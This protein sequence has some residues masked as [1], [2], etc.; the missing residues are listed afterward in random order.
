LLLTVLLVVALRDV[1]RETIVV[2]LLYVLWLVRL[3][4]GSMPQ[5]LFWSVFL[6]VACFLALGSLAREKSARH[7][8]G[9]A[10]ETSSG[11]VSVWARRIRLMARGGY[12]GWYFGQ[13]VEKLI[14][15][16]L[17][18]RERLSTREIRRR[19]K[20][21]DLE[22]PPEVRAYFEIVMMPSQRR[23]HIGILSRFRLFPRKRAQ[24]MLPTGSGMERVVRFL[25]DELEVPYDDRNR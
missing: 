5:M 10:V 2:P 7:D 6:I 11:Q 23:W 21:R 9:P 20:A 4:L 14:A 17:A 24:G 25:E 15:E 12:M 13:H 8:P 1:V 22:A 19:M 3:F 16:V 18:Y